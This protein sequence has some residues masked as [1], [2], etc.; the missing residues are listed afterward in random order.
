MLLL[1]K[2]RKLKTYHPV[3]L[4]GLVD[5]TTA[6]KNQTYISTANLIATE[7]MTAFSNSDGVMQ[8]YCDE[9]TSVFYF[10][11]SPCVSNPIPVR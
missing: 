2:I 9:G 1:R 11:N 3:I 5:L 10:Q 8:E 7:A 4:G 6:T